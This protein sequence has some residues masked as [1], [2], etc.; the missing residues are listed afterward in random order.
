M[1]WEDHGAFTGEISAAMLKEAGCEQ[2]YR[3]GIRSAGGFSGEADET[4][5]VSRQKPPFGTE[6]IPILPAV[7]AS[8]E[9][10]AG[11]ISR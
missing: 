1:H 8:T 6:L 10:E 3:S 2:S 5:E 7:E 9:V 4:V 11:G